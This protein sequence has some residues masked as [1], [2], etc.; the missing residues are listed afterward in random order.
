MT[1]TDSPSPTPA[2]YPPGTAVGMAAIPNCDLCP[3]PTPAAYD[4]ATRMGP[5]GNLCESCYSRY[6][7][8]LG[9]GRGQRLILT[10]GDR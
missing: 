1:L 9:T 8:G 6:G 2:D 10:G 3:D 4:A 7:I 5:W